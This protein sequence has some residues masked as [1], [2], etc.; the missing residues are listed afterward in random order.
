MTTRRRHQ[1]RAGHRRPGVA[2]RL[3]R[4]HIGSL[5]EGWGAGSGCDLNEQRPTVRARCGLHRTRGEPD[6][7]GRD[8]DPDTGLI[9]YD[10]ASGGW[11]Q[12]GG[13]SL[14]TPL[15]AAYEAITGVDG[16]TPQWAY[17]DSALLNDPTTGW[18]GDCGQPILYICD[19]AVGYD[20]PTGIGS[21][22]GAVTPGAPGIGGPSFGYGLGNTYTAGVRARR[23]RRSAA[24]STRTDSTRRIT[25]STEQPRP[26][27]RRPVR[28]TSARVRRPSR[29]PA[30]CQASR[31]G[32]PT[33][34]GWS[35]TTT[36]G[37]IVQVRLG[38]YDD[39]IRA[40]QHNASGDR[41]PRAPGADALHLAAGGWSV[42]RGLALL[43][44]GSA[45]PDGV[46]WTS[47][48]GATGSSFTLGAA[49]G[50]DEVRVAVTAVNALRS[51]D[52]RRPAV[53]V[54]PGAPDRPPP[55]PVMT[56]TA[57]RWTAPPQI[58]AG[59]GRVGD[60]P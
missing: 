21:I 46:T 30:R 4:V 33:T 38:S 20:G 34:T 29:S 53:L 16:T 58:S 3:Q 57:R 12:Y 6:L 8:A 36:D 13:T 32:P 45:L 15:I 52:P 49:D 41:R 19:A 11:L 56:F 50:G 23:R 31:P 14:A 43:I 35:R 2:R 47:I 51:D 54:G 39:P 44:S 55:L 28:S 1:P 25:G 17:T 26:T 10:S 40:G 22:S 18:S 24:A 9:I 48:A 7:L 42:R 59:L 37:I 60:D 27:A 5:D